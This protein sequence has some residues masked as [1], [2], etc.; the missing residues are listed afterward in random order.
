MNMLSSTSA[1]Y[2][3]IVHD[4]SFH[5]C[6]FFVIPFA[7]FLWKSF[8]VLAT[9]FIQYLYIS[10]LVRGSLFSG[11]LCSQEKAHCHSYPAKS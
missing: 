6:V 10:Y 4:I 1:P 9:L 11:Y 7:L 5:F 3:Q 8:L 2:L